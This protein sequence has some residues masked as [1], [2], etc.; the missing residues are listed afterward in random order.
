MRRA[1]GGFA[2]TN[3]GSLDCSKN[4]QSLKTFETKIWTFLMKYIAITSNLQVW[5]YDF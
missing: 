4:T 1:R 2:R 5:K 3:R